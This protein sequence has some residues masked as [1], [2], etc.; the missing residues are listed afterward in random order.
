[1]F[2][3]AKN[4]LLF[5]L[6]LSLLIVV[7]ACGAS[8]SA[9]QPT[10]GAKD[11][12]AAAASTAA[13]ATTQDKPASPLNAKFWYINGDEAN[14]T[15]KITDEQ[16]NPKNP[17]LQVA[18]DIVPGSPDDYFQKLSAA[19]AAGNGPDIF[20]MSPTEW[21]KYAK[22]GIAL[23]LTEWIGPNKDDYYAN[24]INAVTLDGKI[25]ST[26][27]NMD[28]LGLYYNKDMLA[29][30]GVQPPKTWAE[31]LDAAKKLATKDR[32]GLIIETNQG[33]Y[34]N[35]EWY[36]FV[37]MTGNDFLSAD[38]TQVTANNDGVK[39]ALQLYRDLI[40]SGAV[41][42]KLETGGYDASY[43]GQ[44][45][46]AMQ[47]SGSWNVAA[48]FKPD[49]KTGKMAYPDVNVGVV[50]YPVMEAGAKA[51]SDAGG[52]RIMVSTKGKDP[53][54]CAEY[55]NWLANT[56]ASRPADIVKASFKFSARK[57]VN[58]ALGDLYTKYPMDVFTKEILP[59]AGMEPTY[60]AGVVK[61]IEEALQAAMY[62][63]KAIDGIVSELDQKCKDAMK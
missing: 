37:W 32:Y 22:G 16:W 27:A 30:A 46:T 7:T 43:L 62:T 39:K 47:F 57:S 10:T 61:A 45:K 15:K 53:R 25:Y 56:D 41:S 13:A 21:M 9:A 40:K 11:A 20:S 24:P 48:F 17:N 33:G 49:P 34:Q 44:K 59:V 28:L 60:P 54:A 31:L 19:F 23:D 14:T 52:W 42:K 5:V 4:I 63:D 51:S 18:M 36:P 12:T 2:K 38:G 8:N 55:I 35:F 3:F 50:P 29:A 1:M 58:A 26:P 6:V